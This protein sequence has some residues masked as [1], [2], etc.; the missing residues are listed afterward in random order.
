M[1]EQYK[2]TGFSCDIRL[3]AE[4]ERYGVDL[5]TQTFANLP[6]HRQWSTIEY[7]ADGGHDKLELVQRRFASSPDTVTVGCHNSQSLKGVRMQI[8]DPTVDENFRVAYTE[9]PAIISAFMDNFA[10]EGCPRFSRDLV[11]TCELSKRTEV[12]ATDLIHRYVVD[13]LSYE[14]MAPHTQAVSDREAQLWESWKS[15]HGR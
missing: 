14:A 7:M 15:E 9:R 6:D 4:V 13:N 2:F 10:E 5:L 11:I 1:K 3:Y 8:H 12:I